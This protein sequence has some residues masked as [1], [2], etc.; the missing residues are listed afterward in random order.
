MSDKVQ[1][2]VESC[3]TSLFHH[4]LVKLIVVHELQKANRDWAEF[5]FLNRIGI[6]GT[7]VSPQAKEKTPSKI[8]SP[9]ETKSRR[10]DNL[11]P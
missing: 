3:E 11:K 7:G 8:T 5:L 10:F 2:K 6:E 9:V 4:G 1:M